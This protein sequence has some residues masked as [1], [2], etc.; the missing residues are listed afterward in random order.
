MSTTDMATVGAAVLVAYVLGS[1]PSGLWMGQWLRG[2]DIREHGSRNIGATNTLRVLGRQLGA[3]ALTFDMLKGLAPVLAAAHVHPWPHLPLVCGLAAILGH[4]FSIFIRFQGGKGVATSAGVFL[5]LVTY[6]TLIAVA[7]FAVVVGVSRYVSAGSVL[8][9]VTLAIAVF[10]FPATLP[11]RIF[12]VAIA[13]L[14]IVKHRDNLK[15]LARG[16]ENRIGG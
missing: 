4:L 6:P 13:A 10:L 14:V 7:V 3:A 1:V 15:R 8:A 16:E 5:G 12:T 11:V 9:A 2:I